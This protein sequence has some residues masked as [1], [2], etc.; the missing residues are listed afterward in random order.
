MNRKWKIR[1]SRPSSPFGYAGALPPTF[2][3]AKIRTM[4]LGTLKLQ[5][6]KLEP[7]P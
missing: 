5:G 4:E 7:R 6:V 1:R 3:N 2:E